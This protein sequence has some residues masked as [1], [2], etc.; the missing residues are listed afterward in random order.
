MEYTAPRDGS[1]FEDHQSPLPRA[2][3]DALYFRKGRTTYAVTECLGMHCGVRSVRLMVFDGKKKIASLSSE[4][5]RFEV[6]TSVY[7]I[8]G[9]IVQEK[10]SGLNFDE[11]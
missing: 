10:K 4:P 6:N 7:E 1:F 11:N 2:R 5:D 3:I 8:K 9:R